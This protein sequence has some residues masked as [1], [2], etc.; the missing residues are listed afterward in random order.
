MKN[1]TPAV[2]PV[3]VE[4]D[5]SD[6]WAAAV[7]KRALVL[8]S[9]D[10]VLPLLRSHAAML[11]FSRQVS[12][13]LVSVSG[14]VIFRCSCVPVFRYSVAP[15]FQCSS[16]APVFRTGAPLFRCCRCSNALTAVGRLRCTASGTSN[17]C[18]C[19]PVLGL[20]GGCAAV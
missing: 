15:V 14:V 3:S 1:M 16:G 6:E 9:R 7:F 19:R 17:S 4:S 11:R 12:Q 18:L 5:D 2:S 20:L 10:V 8:C 13:C